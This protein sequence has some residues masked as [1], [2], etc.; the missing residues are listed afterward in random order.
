MPL[1]LQG[2]T[3][4]YHTRQRNEQ[5]GRKYYTH[6]FMIQNLFSDED[7][8]AG[9]HDGSWLGEALIFFTNDHERW[10]WRTVNGMKK[11]C[12]N[13]RWLFSCTTTAQRGNDP[14]Q[15]LISFNNIH[16]DASYRRLLSQYVS[17]FFFSRVITQTIF[18]RSSNKIV[19][20]QQE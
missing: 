5:S 3:S 18:R 6:R 15:N 17:A 9:L 2:H 4:L 11:K 19:S 10:R 13:D 1:C 16:I 12:F 8:I 20:C 14:E 7:L